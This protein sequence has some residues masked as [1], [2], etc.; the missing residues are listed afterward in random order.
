M[1]PAGGYQRPTNPAPTS[2]PGALSRRTDGGPGS[3]QAAR[4]VAGMP[5]GEGADFLDIQNMAPMAAAQRT[6]SASAEGSAPSQLA[7]AGG[8]PVIPL[9]A[10]TQ[11]PGV[12]VTDGA[13]RG[14]GAGMDSLGLNMANEEQN[15]AFANQIAQYMPVLMQVAASP[16]ASA[17]TRDVIRR[18]RNML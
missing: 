7:A 3:K 4:Y 17:E 18:L 15:K 6:P 2:G 16:N 1:M 9:N 5:Y 13:D 8:S 12:P 14:P 11:M 10:P